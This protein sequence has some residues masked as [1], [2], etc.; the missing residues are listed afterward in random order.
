MDE[1]YIRAL[2][3]GLPPT[4]GEG[5]GIDRLVMLLTNSPS[6]RDVILF[7][8]DEEARVTRLELRARADYGTS[9]E[10][11][12]MEIPF[13][14]HV[15]VRYLLAK[16]KQAFISV[17]SA[18][19]DRRRRRRRRG[20]RHRAG[21]DDGPAA[22]AARSHPRIEPARVRVAG[23]RH[24]RLS[25]RGRPPATGARGRRRG[26]GGARPGADFRRPRRRTRCR[27]RAS[28]RRSSRASPTSQR[29]MQAGR[30][31][32]LANRGDAIPGIVLGQDLATS[33]GVGVGDSVQVLTLEGVL[34]PMG[35]RPLARRRQVVGHLQARPL[36][37]RLD[38]RV[39]V[40]AGRDAAVRQAAG[41]L[42]PAPGERR[43]PGAAGGGGRRRRGWASSTG[44]RTGR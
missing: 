39:R 32:A 43:V 37:V 38:V 15:A 29:A 12:D 3:Y 20:R 11:T 21:R 33:L 41:R 36:R 25:R 14:L 34:T 26:A 5:V 23:R 18:D 13:E 4:G 19:F 6:I 31:D 28:I 44:P 30:L 16:R 35:N 22:G 9:H 7:P 8:A 42:H 24:R 2:E 10:P 27:S 40:A 1:D 17:I